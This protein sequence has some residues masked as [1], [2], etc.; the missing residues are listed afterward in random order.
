[1][2]KKITVGTSIALI[3]FAILLAFSVTYVCI[4]KSY[5]NKLEENLKYAQI[6]Q[7]L[8]NFDSIIRE[9]YIGEIDG[10]SVMDGML[11]GYLNG[12]GDKYARYYTAEEYGRYELEMTGKVVGIGITVHYNSEKN[13]AEIVNVTEGSPAFK[14]GLKV[15]DLILGVDGLTCAADGYETII[16]AISGE[17][18]EPVTVTVLN[19]EDGI[20]SELHIVRAIVSYSSVFSRVTDDKIGI[21]QITEFNKNTPK[22]FKNVINELSAEGVNSF[23]FDVRNNLGGNLD[24]ICQVLD[25]LLPEGPI[26]RLVDSDGNETT[27]KSDSSCIEGKICVLVNQYT[28]SAAELFASAIRDYEYGTLIGTKTY[29]KGTAQTIMKLPDNSA[30]SISTELYMPPYG[31]NYENIG[32][33][34]D[35]VV[36]YEAGADG[37]EDSQTQ[38]AIDTLLDLIKAEEVIE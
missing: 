27:K 21:V 23:I 10:N 25:L 2:N 8:Y 31:D 32:I 24:A 29:G 28:A 12:L 36:E 18:G 17:E 13:A 38:K 34:P 22:E 19:G 26:V 15:G 20:I 7:K 35:I 1:M 6:Y 9:K 4:N 30:L 11:A 14:M 3:F 16:N 37:K 33:T 5:Q